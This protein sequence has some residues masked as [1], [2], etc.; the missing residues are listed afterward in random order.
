M[1]DRPILMRWTQDEVFQPVGPYWL[2]E[3]QKAFVIG[4]SYRLVT[5][6]ERSQASHNAYFAELSTAFDNLPESL[7][8]LHPT[9]EHLRKHALIRTGYADERQFVC[10]SEAE[11]IRLAAFLRPMDDYAIVLQKGRVCT[12]YT[13]KSQSMKA[14]DKQTFAASRK[15]VLDYVAQLIGVQPAQLG[16]EGQ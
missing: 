2:G 10:S 6:E 7:M 1:S 16:R 9:V 15:A 4:Q 11:A 12:V 13:A 5:V 8:E 3:A 14:M